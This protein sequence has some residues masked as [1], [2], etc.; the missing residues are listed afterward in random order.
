MD[1]TAVTLP[2]ADG[3]YRF[4][5][6]MARIVAAEREANC[7][8]FELFHNLGDH[9]AVLDG[10]EVMA[11]PSPA[12]L[13]QCRALIRN[14]LIGGGQSEERARE[15]AEVYCYPARAAV[16]DAALA[17]KILRA[18][19]YGVQVAEGSKKKAAAASRSRSAKER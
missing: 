7:S 6:P 14:A 18:A 8:I 19:I 3:D 16:L 2:F 4:F 10:A 1:A 17:F 11:G 15:L 9:L 5:L 13:S 12:R